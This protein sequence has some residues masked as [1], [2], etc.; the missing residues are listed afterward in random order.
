VPIDAY[1]ADALIELA[2]RYLTDTD[3]RGVLSR[4]APA[5]RVV[6]S[7]QTLLG[8]SDEPAELAGYGPIPA[9]LARLIAADPD[10]TWQRMVTDPLGHLIDLG[11]TRYRPPKLLADH[12]RARDQT[13]AFPTCNRQAESCELDHVCDWDHGGHTRAENLSVEAVARICRAC[14]GFGGFC[15]IV[16][17]G[18]ER[19]S[20]RSGS[21][22]VDAG[23][24]SGLAS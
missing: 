20:G 22:V 16:G 11:R 8:D 13:C 21:V 6:V 23:I 12:V 10:G 17:Y 24:G 4:Q 2:A 1:R 5:I 15:E 7:L 3:P 14:V 9:S 18:C 19:A